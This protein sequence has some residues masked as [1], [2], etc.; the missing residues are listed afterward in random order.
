MSSTLDQAFATNVLKYM[1]GQTNTAPTAPV[2]VRA[3]STQ[4]TATTNGTEITNAGG[5]SYS[6]QN[7]GPGTPAAGSVGNSAAVA[8]TNMPA[9]T[10][11]AVELWD[12]A[13]T[14]ARLSQGSLTASKTTALGDT[15]SFAAGALTQ[16][17]V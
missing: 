13:G 3:M 5:S 17:M 10:T 9:A 4:G 16:A 8:F 15:L 11:V 12:S 2:K 7:L 14:P 1:M 6:P